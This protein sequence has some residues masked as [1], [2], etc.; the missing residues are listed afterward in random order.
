[1][2]TELLSISQVSEA[3]GLNSSA[4]RYYE[5]AGLIESEE[6]IGGRR[7]YSASVLQRLAVIR[8]LQEAGFTIAEISELIDRKGE[9]W[10]SLAEKKLGEIDAHIDRVT[11]ARDLL[12]SAIRCGCDGLEKCELVKQRHGRHGKMVETMLTPRF[13]VARS[14]NEVSSSE[15]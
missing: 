2:S 10:R 8:M 1:M 3:T 5:R 11:T 15:G 14:R 9:G 4:L 6:R 7:H 12:A 13:P